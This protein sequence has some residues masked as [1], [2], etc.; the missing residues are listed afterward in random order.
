MVARIKTNFPGRISPLC[1]E[2]PG[3]LSRTTPWAHSLDGHRL[4][5]RRDHFHGLLD[6]RLPC[7]AARTRRRDR[8][9]RE[10]APIIG[11]FFQN[12]RAINRDFAGFA[13]ARRLAG[14]PGAGNRYAA[15]A[16]TPCNA[17]LPLMLARYLGLRLLG[18]GITALVAGF[19]AGMAGNVSAARIPS[20]PMTSTARSCVRPRP[21][22]ITYL[23]DA[24][25]PSSAW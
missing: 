25:A 18:L 16:S 22:P 21:T 10:L 2:H 13:R 20:G 4:R 23:W 24:G 17:V 3:R 1:L 6:H 12:V 14:A 11:S 8:S 9:V 7:C 19:M 15:E 5:P